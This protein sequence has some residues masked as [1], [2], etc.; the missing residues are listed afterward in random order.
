M[1]KDKVLVK[2]LYQK[3]AKKYK[4]TAREIEELVTAPHQFTYEKLRE[5]N[6]DEVESEEEAESLKT[7]FNYK[8]LGKLYFSWPSLQTRKNRQ[9]NASKLNKRNGKS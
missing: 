6:F 7:N 9:K 8:G 3:L 4:M 1:D 5:I 2:Q